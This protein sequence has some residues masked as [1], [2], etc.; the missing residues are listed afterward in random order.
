MNELMSYTET[1]MR[2]V[3]LL[4]DVSPAPHAVR[5]TPSA[6]AE[7]M[8]AIL[9]INLIG[10]LSS[11]CRVST[12]KD[13]AKVGT[14]L[15]SGAPPRGPHVDGHGRDDQHA[16]DDVLPVGRH[17]ENV[18]AVVERHDHEQAQRRTP[19]AAAA[20]HQAGAADDHGGDRV[21]LVSLSEVGRT[22]DHARGQHPSG[23]PGQQ[24]GDRVHAEQHVLGVDTRDL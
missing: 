24:P 13:A 9:V 7:A 21:E 6:P 16:L 1:P 12:V 15:D 23:D 11:G 5:P 3:S 4:A 20:T 22:G 18:E 19:D 2:L 8:A 10:S 14:R 17:D